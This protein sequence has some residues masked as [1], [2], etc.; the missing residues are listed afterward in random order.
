MNLIYRNPYT[1]PGNKPDNLTPPVDYNMP[2]DQK[3]YLFPSAIYYRQSTTQS[4]EYKHRNVRGELWPYAAAIPLV[5][6]ML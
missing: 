1:I 2:E 6:G 5:P 3:S 4:A